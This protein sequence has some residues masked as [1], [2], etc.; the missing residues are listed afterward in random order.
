MD[1]CLRFRGQVSGVRGHIPVGDIRIGVADDA[2]DFLD[3]VD[4]VLIEMIVQ[5]FRG[6]DK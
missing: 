4:A 1:Q 3:D 5:H 2:D 6:V